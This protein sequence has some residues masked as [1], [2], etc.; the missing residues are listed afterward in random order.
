MREEDALRE[1][2]EQERRKVEGG[3]Q[4]TGTGRG[5]GGREGRRTEEGKRVKEEENEREPSVIQNSGFQ[6]LSLKSSDILYELFV[7]RH[8]S[9]ARPQTV[10]FQFDCG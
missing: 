8:D 6:H 4:E 7:K 2:E 9:R 3:R 5:G 1:E 10:L